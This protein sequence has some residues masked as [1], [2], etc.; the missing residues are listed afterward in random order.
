MPSALQSTLPRVM[1][2]VVVP[3][4]LLLGGTFNTIL[5]PALQLLNVLLIGMTLCAWAIARIGGRWTWH[6]TAL[7]AAVQPG[8]ESLSGRRR[9][10]VVGRRRWDDGVVVARPGT[11]ALEHRVG[12]AA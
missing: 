8:G 2:M 11:S 4:V 3:Y 10:A 9:R 5:Y 12:P 6:V 1:L 7:D